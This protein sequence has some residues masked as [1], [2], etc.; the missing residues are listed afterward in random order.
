MQKRRNVSPVMGQDLDEVNHARF[1][2]ARAGRT[3]Y[4][5]RMQMT[6]GVSRQMHRTRRRRQG[7][8]SDVFA[9]GR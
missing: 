2:S 1:V 3:T 4:G 6:A 7:V 5:T 9:S 8:G